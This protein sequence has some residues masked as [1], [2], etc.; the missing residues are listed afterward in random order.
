MYTLSG[1]KVLWNRKGCPMQTRCPE[2]VE[3]IC[4]SLAQSHFAHN[5]VKK[6]VKLICNDIQ[7]AQDMRSQ[8]E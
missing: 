7:T 6:F 5:D 2:R 3:R 4:S 8:E 1:V